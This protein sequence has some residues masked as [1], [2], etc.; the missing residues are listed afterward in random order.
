MQVSGSSSSKGGAGEVELKQPLMSQ[1]GDPFYVAKD[2]IEAALRSVRQMCQDLE[3]NAGGSS[4]SSSSRAADR[5]G[6]RKL[7]LGNEIVAEIQ[8]LQYDL[9]DVQT[10]IGI[11]EGNPSKFRV[12]QKELQSRKGFVQQTENSLKQILASTQATIKRIESS[13]S[14]EARQPV[15]N[16]LEREREMDEVVQMGRHQQRQ[17]VSRQDEQLAELSKTTERL[18]QTALVI[19]TELTEQAR[20][21][22]ELDEDIDRETEKLNFVLRRLGILMKT[23]DSK[24]LWTILVLFCIFMFLLMLVIG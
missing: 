6:P 10:T 19:N 18:N 2:E 14:G 16:R 22:T 7:K 13:G 24:Q 3:M 8:Q 21:L 20:M 1:A 11:V 15:G 17:L 5:S 23:S 4:S 9:Q 12:D